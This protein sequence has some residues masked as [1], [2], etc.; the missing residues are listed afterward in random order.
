MEPARRRGAG[1]HS[2]ILRRIAGT[3]IARKV[4]FEEKPPANVPAPLRGQLCDERRQGRKTAEARRNCAARRVGFCRRGR[5]TRRDGD[6]SRCDSFA[7]IARGVFRKG[8]GAKSFRLGR[9]GF[10]QI[11]RGPRAGK[12]LSLVRVI[13]PRRQQTNHLRAAFERIRNSRDRRDQCAGVGA[14]RV[15]KDRSRTF[16][17][18]LRHRGRIPARSA[19]RFWLRFEMRFLSNS[20]LER[21]RDGADAPDLAGTRYRLLERIARG[22]MGVVY[23]AED[24]N[25]Q[26]RVA[27][28]VLDVPGIDGDLANRLLREARVLAALEHP[29]IVPVHDVGT[30][31]D[32]RVFY[33]MKFVEGKRLDRF[34]ESVESVPDRLRIFLR[35]CDAVAFAHARGVLHRDLKPPNIMVGP[36]GEVLVMDWG[37]AKILRPEVSNAPREADPEVTV[38]EKPKQSA[39]TS[40]TT[41]DSVRTGHGTVMGTPGYM[42]PEQAR[43]DV[44]HLDAR[45]DIYSLGALLRFLLTGKPE[46]G[47]TQIGTRFDK[48]LASIFAKAAATL[49]GGRYSNVSE[50][51]L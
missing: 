21:L 13:R 33:T 47:S 3:R 34:I 6:G 18:T 28:K 11:V 23:A 10:A 31:A 50:L 30:L 14:P 24:E 41:E 2:G 49:P 45:S 9:R 42:S 40:D 1:S 12:N 22:G 43:G 39:N 5:G 4:R 51:A 44:E 35:I 46:E 16:A 36:F 38:F 7:R 25:L 8:V 26:R 32:G 19:R 48:S 17:R 37:L 27:L 15:S 29:G 20:A